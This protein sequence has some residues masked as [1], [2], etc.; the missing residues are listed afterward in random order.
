MQEPLPVEKTPQITDCSGIIKIETGN[1]NALSETT[2]VTSDTPTSQTSRDTETNKLPS[3]GIET[4][5]TKS[6]ETIKQSTFHM[7]SSNR[8]IVNNEE[9]ILENKQQ[10]EDN[11]HANSVSEIYVPE[12]N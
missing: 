12:D 3:N 5:S 2:N 6:E 9:D 7:Q 10:E 8:D 11:T 4:E 1:D